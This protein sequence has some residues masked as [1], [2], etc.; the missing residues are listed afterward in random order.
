MSILIFISILLLAVAA[1]TLNKLHRRPP[2]KSSSTLS[3]S[4]QFDGL[5]AEQHASESRQ[6]DGLFAEQHA[7]DARLIAQAETK[8]RSEEERKRLLERA[9]EGDETALDEAHKKGD[10]E[11]YREVLRTIVVQA[12]GNAEALRSIA[13]YIVDGRQLRSNADFAQTMIE[14]WGKS[15]D[16]R[17]LVDML[18]LSALSDDGATFQRALEAAFKKWRAGK[19]PQISAKDFLATVECAY[20][21]IATEVRYSGSGFLIK[22]AIADIRRELAATDR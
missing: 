14:I 16:Q 20:W 6:F 5:F 3:E 10:A 2:S 7:E 22:Q 21:L 13:E 18:Y 11:L 15:H 12:D 9:G 19:L 8:L 17:S 1:F 4:R